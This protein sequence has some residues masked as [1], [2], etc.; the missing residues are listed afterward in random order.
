VPK[1]QQRRYRAENEQFRTRACGPSLHAAK[2]ATALILRP[3]A[4][5]ENPTLGLHS[6]ACESPV[7]RENT[8]LWMRQT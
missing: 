8:V 3:C 2:I 1:V 5:S 7:G 4:A 6:G